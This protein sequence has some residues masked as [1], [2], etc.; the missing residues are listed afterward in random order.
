MALVGYTISRAILADAVALIRGDRYFTADYTPYNLTAWGFA[1][2][3]RSG[4]NAGF[5]G[6]FGRLLL[7]TL[8]TE[9]TENST[10]TWFPMMTPPAMNEVL[11]E[12]NVKDYDLSRPPS[13]KSSAEVKEYGEVVGVLANL[14]KFQ[15]PFLDRVYSVI[16]GPGSVSLRS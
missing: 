3:Q 1:D 13:S 16:N 11:T 2:C 6:M 9:Y 5:G 4:E 14:T 10:Y 12:L 8:P 15:D 7:R